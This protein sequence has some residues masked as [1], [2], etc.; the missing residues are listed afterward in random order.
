MTDPFDTDITY[1]SRA[2]ALAEDGL[3][4]VTPNPC[5]GCV[6][7][8]DG[9]VIGEGRTQDGGRPHAEAVALEQAGDLAKGATVYVTL[10]PCF[11][12]DKESCS[13]RLIKAGVAKIVV[14]CRDQNPVINGRGIFALKQ[15]GIE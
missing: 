14:G 3:G 7:V 2:L 5:V 13:S 10:E 1:M 4:R 11:H 12:E 6:I 8:K 9:K 15:S